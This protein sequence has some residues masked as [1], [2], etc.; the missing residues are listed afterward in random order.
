MTADRVVANLTFGF[1]TNI[2]RRGSGYH[3]NFWVPILSSAFPR[4]NNRVFYEERY[5]RIKKLRN[6]IAHHE[7]IFKQNL[8]QEYKHSEDIVSV[9]IF[10]EHVEDYL[11]RRHGAPTNSSLHTKISSVEH[12]LTK[13]T[14]Y[15]A[16]NLAYTLGA[17]EKGES[18]GSFARFE[19]SAFYLY[20]VMEWDT[21]DKYVYKPKE[22]LMVEPKSVGENAFML[23]VLAMCVLVASALFGNH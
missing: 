23:L 18:I 15:H 16:R 12:R 6:R 9:E 11:V 20:G 8:E 22:P 14:V 3:A 1:W 4:G 10:C 5:K 7:P 13:T 17:L 21:D 19:E 2:L